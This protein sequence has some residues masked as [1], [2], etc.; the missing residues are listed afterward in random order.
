MEKIEKVE[1][2][3][4]ELF[5]SIGKKELESILSILIAVQKELENINPKSPIK[6]FYSFDAPSNIYVIA[7]ALK[8]PKEIY[9][10]M[11]YYPPTE[12]SVFAGDINNTVINR[13]FRFAIRNRSDSASMVEMIYK[14][15]QRQIMIHLK[16]EH[17]YKYIEISNRKL[18][19]TEYGRFVGLSKKELENKRVLCNLWKKKSLELFGG[20]SVL[21][22]EKEIDGMMIDFIPDEE[23]NGMVSR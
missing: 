8:E 1:V 21:I 11:Q 19:H 7:F 4:K 9:T 23:I 17:F 20:T 2:Y 3:I 5:P 6:P 15:H 14:S 16:I 13:S 18:E 12:S 10:V 22:D